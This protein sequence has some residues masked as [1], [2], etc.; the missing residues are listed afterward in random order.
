MNNGVHVSEY[1]DKV[2]GYYGGKF[3]PFHNGHLNCIIKA[4]QMVDV[5]FVVVGYDDE[6]DKSICKNTNFEWVTSNTRERWVTEAVRELRNIRVL[7]NYEPRLD[8]YLHN[9]EI[10]KCNDILLEKV[11]GRIDYAFSSEESYE[12]YFNEYLPSAKH[13]VLDSERSELNVSAT[14]IR[15]KG[16]YKMWDYLPKSVQKDYTKKVC[17]CGVESTGK[18]FLTKQLATLY[19][20]TYVTEYGRDFY[21]DIG[22]CFDIIRYKDLI[23][24]ACGHNHL[25][26]KGIETANKILFVDTDN[27]YTQ[28]FIKEEYGKEDETVA[29]IINSNIDEIDLYIYL[30]PS[31]PHELDGMRQAKTIKDK[32]R[33]NDVLKSMYKNYEKDIQMVDSITE[34]DNIKGL[35]ESLFIH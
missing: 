25:I 3:L 13:I 33:E 30:E 10:K 24:I 23:K 2:V 32:Q 26:E 18:S 7:T 21:E 29:S 5:L 22:G 31:I 27:I 19:N 16:V 9:D 1:K 4:S 12:G 35:I 11:G 34:M 20:T 6:Y 15:N 28:F 14:Q 17:I 8:D